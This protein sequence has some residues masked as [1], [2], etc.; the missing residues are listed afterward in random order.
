VTDA[1]LAEQVRH[2]R[3]AARLTQGEL[4]DRAGL[5]ERA[6]SDIERGLR[7]RVYPVT[8]H[9]LADAL[10]L[11][12]EAR[13][14][15]ERAA[16][17][18]RRLRRRHQ[19]PISSLS[20]VADGSS[21]PVA[22][23]H[24]RAMRRTPM[25]GREDE[26]EFLLRSL[27]D[28]GPRLH[29]ITGPG[30]MGKSRLAAE[31]CA[32]RAG[33]GVAWVSLA[34]L[35]Q[36]E[37]VLSAIA[38]VAGL[39]RDASVEVL[40]AALEVGTR[41]LVLDTFEPVLAAANE[42]AGLL[43]RTTRLRLLVTSRAPL[44][45]RG[46]R[47]LLLRPLS[48]SAATEL[49]RQRVH[50]ARP[51]L[52]VEDPDAAAAIEEIGRQLSGLPLALELAAAKV[53][54]VSL[55]ALR[56]RLD[57]PLELLDDGER[58]LPPR[59]QTMRAALGWSYDL[60]PP[61]EQTVFRRLA[62]FV[63]GW[64]FEAAEQVCSGDG[65]PA[66]AT[67]S[68]LG[69]LCEHGLV[70]PDDTADERWR[71][72]DPIRDYALELLDAAGERAAI[73]HR[74]ALAFANLAE[75]AATDLLGP[76]QTAVRD[77]LR[78][79]LGNLRLVLSWAIDTGDADVALRV[80]GATW[81]FWR[82]ESAFTEGRHWLERAL[83]MPRA[84]ESSFRSP[85]L[86]GAAWLAY[87]QGDREA[88]AGY[89]RE[90]IARSDGGASVDRRNGLTILGH[91]ALAE[92][93]P[94]EAVPLLEQALSIARA[95]GI[96][97]HVATSLLNLGTALLHQDDHARA[98]QVLAEA[99]AEHEAGGDRLFAARCRVELGYAALVCE[100]LTQARECFV[101]ALATFVDLRERWGEAEAIRG[102][103]VLAAARGDAV[104]A[105][106]LTGASDATYADVAARVIAPDARL[107]EPFLRRA[108]D[109]L[110]EPEW[111]TAVAHGRALSI[112]QAVQ[113]A[114]DDTRD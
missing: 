107:A 30:G 78:T 39:P 18:G 46:E 37:F 76:E 61:V 63:D 48:T 15:L 114:V 112:E 79:E 54:Y 9:A 32:E 87:Q 31:V 6:I 99:M 60:L 5:S 72:L 22:A 77:E 110:G 28:D 43:D 38:A 24:W 104:T 100:D 23:E 109:T 56:S 85:A 83:A 55:S 17:A 4:A 49:F 74:H 103:A 89:G 92:G 20:P 19:P 105:A 35:R 3:V 58:D 57:R 106:M 81:M 16:Q 10:E 75:H 8:A 93:R 14:S 47:E 1:D 80:A 67:M 12:G 66:A 90:L 69:H 102:A 96:R 101:A 34:A 29:S 82:M 13:A 7:A 2:Y 65:A 68:A 70:Q 52:I 33:E 95:V 113:L 11:T 27:R 73:Q 25:V 84:Q 44:R 94:S 21:A 62:V 40:A 50:A 51:D 98:R 64:T 45:V 91:L 41:L 71:L 111:A 36:P 88:A 86:W 108:R 53:R 59:Q 97:W 42:V 26:L